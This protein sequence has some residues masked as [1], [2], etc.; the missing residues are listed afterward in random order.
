M[1]IVL[2]RTLLIYA[3]LLITMRLLGKRQLGEMELSE[4]VVAA[5]IADLAALPLQDIGIPMLNAAVP[6]VTL[7]CCE[8][9]I[10][11]LSMKSLRLRTLL[12]GR[13][14]ILI[15]GG[16][17]LQKELRRNRFTVDELLQELRSQG[18][19][20]IRSVE[21]AVLETDGRL[22]VLLCASAQPVNPAQLGLAVTEPGYPIVLINDGRTLSAN[23]R[24]S[25]H[26]EAWLAKQLKSRG[27]ENADQVFLMTVNTAGDI[28]L[29]K[30][31]AQP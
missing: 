9:L 26:D 27:I 22:N 8:L 7:F 2:I 23:L 21:T 1:A 17:I 16:R 13:P 20:D 3:L 28:Y 19:A 6:I 18:I 11:G 24:H 25:G 12:F 15:S 29:A 5:V 30:R 14:S 10:A 4:F 31:E